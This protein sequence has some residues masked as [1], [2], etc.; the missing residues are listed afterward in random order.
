VLTAAIVLTV[1]KRLIL[2]ASITLIVRV[3]N[4]NS[5]HYSTYHFSSNQNANVNSLN[6]PTYSELNTGLDSLCSS[7]KD[8]EAGMNNSVTLNNKGENGVDILSYSN[9]VTRIG[10]DLLRKMVLS[11]SKFNS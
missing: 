4:T 7:H 6:I 8:R 2:T 1:S 5:L 11:C 10:V 9:S 3:A